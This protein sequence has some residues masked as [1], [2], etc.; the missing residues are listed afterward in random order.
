MFA[1]DLCFK[2]EEEEMLAAELWEA[3]CAGIDM[4]A[5]GRLSAFFESTADQ[6]ALTRR[7]AAWNANPRAIEHCDWELEARRSWE[8]RLV[9]RSWFLA[10]DWSDE[11]TPPG[12]FRISVNPGLACGT[13]AHECTRLC[14]EALERHLRPGIAVLDIGT[15][16][17]ILAAAAAAL[18]ARVVAC[19]T[20]PAAV[21]IARARVPAPV[22][23][24]AG[25]AS[26]LATGSMDVA[27]ANI[28]AAV[29]VDLA[30]DL[31][32]V[33]RAGGVIVVSGFEDHERPA[34]EA[35][36]GAADAAY[37]ENQWVLLEYTSAFTRPA[38]T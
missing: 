9:G 18:G 7:F 32:R 15:G 25:S 31:R 26:A 6:T 23:L 20:D 29:C 27:V 36:C 16:S 28:S 13:G 1:L 22:C 10:P 35:A 2:Q 5:A 33:V 3:G 38:R 14:L 12:Y 17:G 34:V 19:D 24:F 11:P 30:L 8:P 21:E 4:T 37:R